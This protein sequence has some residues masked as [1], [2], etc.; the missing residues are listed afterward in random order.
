MNADVMKYL[1]GIF[2][3]IFIYLVVSNGQNATKV[4]N[5][6]SG[7]NTNAIL[8]LQGRTPSTVIG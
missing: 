5:S 8:A 3:L 1:G 6:L 7:A 2:F 4:I